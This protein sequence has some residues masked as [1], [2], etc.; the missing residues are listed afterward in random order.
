MCSAYCPP[1]GASPRDS[2]SSIDKLN[3]RSSLVIGADVNARS[4]LWSE[5]NNAD[6][7]GRDME[8]FLVRNN[9]V[10]INNPSVAT[11]RRTG[12]TSPDITVLGSRLL[13][14]LCDWNVLDY[15][16]LSDHS[17]ITFSLDFEEAEFQ[18]NSGPVRYN[19]KKTD[20]N[21]FSTVLLQDIDGIYS[22]P[23]CSREDIDVIVS[24]LTN[25]IQ[26]CTESSTPRK[27]YCKFSNYKRW[28]NYDL[29]Q[30]R[31]N[32]RRADRAYKKFRSPELETKLLDAK[33]QYGNAIRKAKFDDWKRFCAEQASVDPWN[34][35]HKVCS[36]KPPPV[37]PIHIQKSDGSQTSSYAEA[38]E[39]LLKKWF[40][41]DDLQ[42]ES[43]YHKNI[44]N[45]VKE[46]LD[47]ELLNLLR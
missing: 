22:L 30:L 17:Y 32:F 5:V 10:V 34:T 26:Q 23:V 47:L 2:V 12:S 45:E 27:S 19:Y 9:L 33:K 16:S 21:I 14:K 29:T 3:N 37:L 42:S 31:R 39:E 15:P 20:W 1:S 24:N 35:I 6:K 43:F 13:S 36:S 44:R 8:Q 40:P 18:H 41:S 38:G 4:P 46:K 7:R 25:L 28:W 11:Y